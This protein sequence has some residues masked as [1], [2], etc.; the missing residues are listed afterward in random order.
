MYGV[1]VTPSA[2]ARSV[3]AAVGMRRMVSA[4]I[5]LFTDWP[6]AA[7]SASAR[8][9]GGSAIRL[10]TTRWLAVSAAPPK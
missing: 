4:R 7:M 6:R 3:R 1:A 10:S 9:I 8:M 5:T 2:T